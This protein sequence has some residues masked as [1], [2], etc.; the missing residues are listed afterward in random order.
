MAESEH[1]YALLH[2]PDYEGESLIGVY[3]CQG[4]ALKASPM[5]PTKTG[6]FR[7]MGNDEE[8]SIRDSREAAFWIVRKMLVE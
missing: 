4:D 5:Q 7:W 6:K 3:R 1:V 8:M 2:S